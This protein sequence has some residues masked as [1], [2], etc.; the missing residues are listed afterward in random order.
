MSLCLRW[1]KCRRD[2]QSCAMYGVANA[3]SGR[4]VCTAAIAFTG[5]YNGNSS[6]KKCNKRSP[7]RCTVPAT[8]A[9]G[10]YFQ[11]AS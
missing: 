8:V 5:T 1:V 3:S 4:D 10:T 11:K 9:A 6:T 7:Q 2:K